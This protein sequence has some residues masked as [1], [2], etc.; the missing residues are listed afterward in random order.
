LHIC[1]RKKAV[2]VTPG[3]K[4]IYPEEVEAELLRSRFIAECLVWGE[5]SSDPNHDAEVQ[6]IVVPNT[7]AFI[8]EGMESEGALDSAKVEEVLRREVK[9]CCKKLASFKR[10]TRLTVRYEEFEKTTTR[11]IKRYLYTK[12]A[13]TVGSAAERTR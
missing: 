5:S 10:V 3:G 4:K 9:E 11:K 6:A 13:E 7:E 2:I 8:Q 1:G 12:P